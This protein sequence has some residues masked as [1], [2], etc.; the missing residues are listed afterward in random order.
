MKEALP[1]MRPDGI[2]EERPVA[3]PFEPI[4][5]AILLIGPSHGQFIELRD[6]VVDNCS[7]AH[8]R[9]NDPV[10]P[11]CQSVEDPLQAVLLDCELGVDHLR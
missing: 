8:G 9:A 6:H 2:A 3:A 7:I 10:A 5:P 4:S 1:G 11:A